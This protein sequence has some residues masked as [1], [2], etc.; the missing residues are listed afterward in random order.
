MQKTYL[1]IYIYYL[2]ILNILYK[3][4]LLKINKI[5]NIIIIIII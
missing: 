5:F 4:K 3:K 1:Y 2:K